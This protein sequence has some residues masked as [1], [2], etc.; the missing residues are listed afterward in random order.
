MTQG[1]ALVSPKPSA[2]L[3]GGC[4]QTGSARI[5]KL[6]QLPL[7]RPAQ[8]NGDT[9]NTGHSRPR[10][11]VLDCGCEAAA[12]PSRSQPPHLSRRP[13]RMPR[14]R[15]ASQKLGSPA[16]PL[17]NP[18]KRSVRSVRSIRGPSALPDRLRLVI[19]PNSVPNPAPI[20]RLQNPRPFA[21]IPCVFVQL[22]PSS[23]ARQSAI[24]HKNPITENR[25]RFSEQVQPFAPCPSRN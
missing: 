23:Q 5:A 17:G 14:A 19:T 7:L 21:P 10:A 13:W 1:L 6:A 20:P 3:R 2:C 16:N 4:H 12:F 24:I 11:S 22:R 15:A 25:L 9:P 18:Q 8:A